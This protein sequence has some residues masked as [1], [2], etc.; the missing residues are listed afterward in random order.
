MLTRCPDRDGP[1][2]GACTDEHLTVTQTTGTTAGGR[3]LGTNLVELC[4]TTSRGAGGGR[5]SRIRLSEGIFHVVCSLRPACGPVLLSCRCPPEQTTY[6]RTAFLYLTTVFT[7]TGTSPHESACCYH[8]WL[9]CD[10]PTVPQSSHTS[11][12][13]KLRA[14]L[15]R[16][17]GHTT[18]HCNDYPWIAVCH[19]DARLQ[20]T[21]IDVHRYPHMHPHHHTDGRLM[22]STPPQTRTP[23]TVCFL[24]HW[25]ASRV[26]SA[27]QGV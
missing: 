10:M 6:V 1:Q 19:H 27:L 21:L 20:L 15:P 12:P 9:F 8:M 23:T 14:W 16:A 11:C 24:A 4:V 5:V 13:D 22:G 3:G 25:S 7:R 2:N 17:S 18:H 26:P